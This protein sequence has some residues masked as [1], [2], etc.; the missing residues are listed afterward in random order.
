MV[1][2][3]KEFVAEMIEINK[4][5]KDKLNSKDIEDFENLMVR[6]NET[7]KQLKEFLNGHNIGKEDVEDLT[8]LV[9][10]EQEISNLVEAKIKEI[11][12]AIEKSRIVLRNL[13]K[14]M[15][16]THNLF[17]NLNIKV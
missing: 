17:G 10:S 4:K 7:I 6:K 1:D 9:R 14:Y 2:R 8:V 16:V 12:D 3:I 5:I 13:S 11:G 15:K